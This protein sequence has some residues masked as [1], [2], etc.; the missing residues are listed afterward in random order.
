MSAVSR[1]HLAWTCAYMSC[2]LPCQLCGIGWIAVLTS[3]GI[4]TRE[5]SRSRTIPSPATAAARKLVEAPST[6]RPAPTSTP[7]PVYSAPCTGRPTGC[8]RERTGRG[9]DQGRLA[10]RRRWRA[11]DPGAAAQVVRRPRLRWQRVHLRPE[12][13]PRRPRHAVRGRHAFVDVALTVQGR[14]GLV[15]IHGLIRGGGPVGFTF[16]RPG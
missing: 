11:S 4:C 16:L 2:E 7:G 9:Q 14:A 3:S 5:C 12:H 10:T 8:A 1:F 6:A 15:L 13:A